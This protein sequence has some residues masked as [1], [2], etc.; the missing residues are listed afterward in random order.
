LRGRGYEEGMLNLSE[1]V[2]F[3]DDMIYLFESEDLSLLEHLE[4]DVL[5]SA[6]VSAES[7][8]TKRSYNHQY[9]IVT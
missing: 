9:M 7:H 1:N 4:S 8:S 2:D 6:L 5:S 3:R